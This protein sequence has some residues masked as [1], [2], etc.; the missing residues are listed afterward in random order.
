LLLAACGGN[1]QSTL[2]GQLYDGADQKLAIGSDEQAMLSFVGLD[3]A[4]NGNRERT[5]PCAVG[6]DGSFHMPASGGEMPPGTYRV[7]FE[8]L[9]TKGTTREGR[10]K[11]T[12]KWNGKFGPDNSPIKVEVVAGANNLKVVVPS[13]K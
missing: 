2:K 9:V 3:A 10:P 11:Q 13:G 4:G 7:N 1:G 8:V 5:Y 6:P 12:A